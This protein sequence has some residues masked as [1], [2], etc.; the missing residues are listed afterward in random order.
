MRAVRVHPHPSTAWLVVADHYPLHSP[1]LP[2]LSWLS[3]H[4]PVATAKASTG[5]PADAAPRVSSPSLYSH[6]C[7]SPSNNGAPTPPCPISLAPSILTLNLLPLQSLLTPNTALTPLVFPIA[8]V[9]S[10]SRPSPS[11]SHPSHPPSL[12]VRWPT[13]PTTLPTPRPLLSTLHRGPCS[14]ALV[15]RVQEVPTRPPATI[16]STT[17][18]RAEQELLGRQRFVAPAPAEALIPREGGASEQLMMV[19][20][21]IEEERLHRNPHRCCHH[22]HPHSEAARRTS[23]ALSSRRTTPASTYATLDP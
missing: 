5:I 9:H 13:S 15:H 7:C 10:N 4:D 12:A 8:T 22:H 17:D 14:R 20:M 23:L 16:N 11:R 1:R 21:I 2:S 6:C 18:Q 3:L 19:S